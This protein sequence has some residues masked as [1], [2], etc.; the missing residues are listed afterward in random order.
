MHK[1]GGISAIDH[2]KRCTVKFIIVDLERAPGLYIFLVGS[3]YKENAGH[4]DRHI[5]R[6]IILCGIRKDHTAG[7]LAERIC[8]GIPVSR[9]HSS[10][11]RSSRSS[12]RHRGRRRSLN[13]G[14][15]ACLAVS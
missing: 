14:L 11:G 2:R 3:V 4:R 10:A 12:R 5:R 15:S 1:T 8:T 9:E 7:F 13:T 6:L